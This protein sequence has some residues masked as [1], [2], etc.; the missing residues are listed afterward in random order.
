MKIFAKNKKAFF[1][2]QIIEKFEGGIELIGPEVKYLTSGRVNLTGSYARILT[3]R[4]KPEIF[5]IGSKIGDGEGSE[6]TRKILLHRTEI[7]RLLGKTQEKNLTIIPL[8]FYGKN[9]LIKIELGLGRGK[10]NF[11]KREIIKKRDEERISGRNT[12]SS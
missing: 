12:K 7:N 2:Y 6:R 3:N 11:D 8:T 5:L 1:N 10:K 9:G 4:K